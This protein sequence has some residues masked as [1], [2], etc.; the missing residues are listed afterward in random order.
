MRIV[1]KVLVFVFLVLAGYMSFWPVPVEP[2]AWDAPIDKGF[3][4]DNALNDRLAGMEFLDLGGE[5][6]PEDAVQGNDGMVYAAVHDG[7]ILRIDPVN[8]THSV[9]AETG[10]RPLGLEFGQDGVL[11]AAD[12]N[13]GLLE[14]DATG[15]VTVLADKT[16]DGSP[17]LYADDLDIADDGSIYF[18]DA[19]TRFSAAQYGN[20]LTASILDLVEHSGNG[21]I[22]KYDPVNNQTTVFASGL[23]FANGVALTSDGMGLIVAETG[24]YRILRY[25]LAKAGKEPVEIISSLPGFPDNVNR[26][27]DGTFL[28]GLTSPRNAI[29]DRLSD[30]PFLRTMLVR[31][32]DFLKPGPT[33]HGFILR[34]DAN[35]NVL[36]T[37][38]D[39]AGDYA[40]T[41]GAI[42]LAD[43]SVVITSLSEPRLG[44]LR[45]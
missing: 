7:R 29:V 36:E 37:L 28:A 8:N 12:A 10:G 11:Y 20:T 15:K 2:V 21:R 4:G 41:T 25:E 34:F 22:L 17:I 19:S 30:K 26:G 6:G 14:I 18:S 38:Q 44:I 9:F 35:G 23:N 13:R 27:K 16:S 31:L 39:P 40:L 5:S 24:G 42:D 3:A 33:R 1:G 43:G 45:K 32:P